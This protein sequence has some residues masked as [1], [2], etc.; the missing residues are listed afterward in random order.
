MG[1][2]TTPHDDTETAEA[3][4]E[5][6]KFKEN[7]NAENGE[8]TPL[9]RHMVAK[10]NHPSNTAA[11]ARRRLKTGE[12]P[13]PDMSGADDSPS[14]GSVSDD[15]TTTG[16]HGSVLTANPPIRADGGTPECPECES[17]MEP[18]NGQFKVVGQ[19]DGETEELVTEGQEHHCPDCSV[20]TDGETTV[21]SA[22]VQ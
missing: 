4:P 13:D 14:G 15:Y 11:E 2:A 8:F 16:S 9:M 6:G 7:E 20:V 10:K 5:C 22:K 21:T 3:C 18:V 12:S 1:Q 17:G 19:V